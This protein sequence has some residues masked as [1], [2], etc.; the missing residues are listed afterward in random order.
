MAFFILFLGVRKLFA[1][2]QLFHFGL[3]RCG[4]NTEYGR[5]PIWAR[6]TRFTVVQ[7]PKNV[8]FFKVCQ[9]L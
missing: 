7:Y 3:K 9:G 2:A 8:F 1:N 4:W 6:N 5:R